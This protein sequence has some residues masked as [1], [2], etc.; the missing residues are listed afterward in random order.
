MSFRRAIEIKPYGNLV[1]K[2]EQAPLDL[3]RGGNHAPDLINPGAGMM[4][5]QCS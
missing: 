4:L 2:E 1:K 5:L 3:D